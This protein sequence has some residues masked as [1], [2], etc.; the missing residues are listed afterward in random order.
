MMI[1]KL[2]RI[3]VTVLI[4]ALPLETAAECSNSDSGD[5][6]PDKGR[7]T[8]GGPRPKVQN[9]TISEVAITVYYGD[10][11]QDLE[12]GDL[13][14]FQRAATKFCLPKGASGDYQV[15]RGAKRTLKSGACQ[16]V[17]DNGNDIASVVAKK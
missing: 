6:N 15:G 9:S 17:K 7:N 16:S 1:K 13:S 5:S 14:D 4:L 3:V 8:G 12:P 10:E 11:T 2:I